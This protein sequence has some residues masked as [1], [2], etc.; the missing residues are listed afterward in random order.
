MNAKEQDRLKRAWT[1]AHKLVTLAKQGWP[2]TGKDLLEVKTE[3]LCKAMGLSGKAKLEE[4]RKFVQDT[5][6]FM[7]GYGLHMVCGCGYLSLMVA[8]SA[9]IEQAFF[10]ER[11]LTSFAPE[12]L[13]RFFESSLLDM[14]KAPGTPVR[15]VCEIEAAAKQEDASK[16]S[17]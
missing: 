7:Q 1:L 16:S 2:E 9:S 8:R 14:A 11:K 5:V 10:E 3:E 6:G 4:L 12:S 17:R 13:D 15:Q